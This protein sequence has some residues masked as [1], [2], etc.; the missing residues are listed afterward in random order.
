MIL[1]RSRSPPAGEEVQ[2]MT[3]YNDIHVLLT[4]GEIKRS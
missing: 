2:I 3:L 4:K 1:V